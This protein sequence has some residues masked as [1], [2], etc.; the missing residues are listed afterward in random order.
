MTNHVRVP[1]L[2]GES[3]QAMNQWFEMLCSEGLLFH[4][5]DRPQDIVVLKTG[6][7]TFSATECMVLSESLARLFQYHGDKVYD[8]ALEFCQKSIGIDPEYASP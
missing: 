4:P 8:V 1:K 5:D 2:L 7:P 6:E 3:V